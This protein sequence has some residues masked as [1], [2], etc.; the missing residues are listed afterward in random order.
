MSE[1]ESAT[2]T[3]LWPMLHGRGK[4]LHATGQRTLA[5]WALKTALVGQHAH[6]A[7]NLV[8]SDQLN[9]H[10][11]LHRVA[12]NELRIW[13]ASY[14]GAQPGAMTS[15]GLDLDD[16]Q[17]PGRGQ[18]DIAVATIT[19]G[20]VVFL[21]YAASE[22]SLRDLVTDWRRP[23]VWPLWPYRSTFTW[24]PSPAFDDRGLLAFADTIPNALLKVG[25]SA[26]TPNPRNDGTM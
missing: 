3:L 12:P 2:K 19:L 23:N 17:D 26:R 20:P 22:A 24:L 16:R 5:T 11:M 25:R 6:G 13:M 21:V 9:H 14:T 8:F 15:T 4:A 7:P 10:L 1:V 18:R